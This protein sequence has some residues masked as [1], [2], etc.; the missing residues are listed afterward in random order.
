MKLIKLILV[1]MLF[2]FGLSYSS[3]L[4]YKAPSYYS[5]LK[6]SDLV[7]YSEIISKTDTTIILK[8]KETLKGELNTNTIEIEKFRDWPCASRHHE[9]EIGQQ[10]F[11]ILQKLNDG[12][13]IGMS[14]GNECELPVALG[15]VYCKSLFNRESDYESQYGKIRG[16]RFDFNESIEGLQRMICMIETIESKKSDCEI[17]QLEPATTIESMIIEE[18]IM[19]KRLKHQCK[20]TKDYDF[21]VI[22]QKE[23]WH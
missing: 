9:Y 14:A 13:Y 20:I 11:N 8:I 10:Q 6:N 3:N 5:M 15:Y 21:K 2:Q 12:S 1:L 23:Y 22:N 7:I 17:F 16:F 4:D 18:Q 19:R